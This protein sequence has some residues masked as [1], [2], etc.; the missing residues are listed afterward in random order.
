[1][2]RMSPPLIVT[3]FT[4]IVVLG[5]GCSKPQSGSRLKT[6]PTFG[7]VEVD[8]QPAEGV[9]VTCYPDKDTSEYQRPLGTITGGDGKFAFSTY[10][11]NDGLPEGQYKLVF[12]WNELGIDKTAD[13]L[14]GNYTDPAKSKIELFVGNGETG[15]LGIIELS[16]NLSKR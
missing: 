15:N 14:G 2:L 7:V 11:A 13:R 5:L 8:G 16:T 1:M 9:F 6:Y 3:G 10:A 4:M 12:Q